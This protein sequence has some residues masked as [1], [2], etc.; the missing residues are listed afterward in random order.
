MNALVRAA[1]L[2]NYQ[3]VAL[4]SGLNPTR[5]LLDE[6]LSPKVLQEPDWMIPVGKV[7]R[8]LHQSAVLSGNEGIG[9]S[10]ARSRKLSNLGPVGLLIRDQVTLRDALNLLVRHLTLLNSALTVSLEENSHSVCIRE[11]LLSAEPGEPTRQRVELALGVMVQVIRQLISKDWCPLRVCFEHAAPRNLDV[12]TR[13]FGT[14]VYFNQ[15]FNGIVCTP[16]DLNARNEFADPAMVRYVHP[17]ME[18]AGS[19]GEDCT[20]EEVRRMILLLLPSGCCS[21]E[22]VS[23]RLGVVPRTIQRRLTEKGETFSSTMNEIRRQL[24]TR[25]VLESKRSLTDISDLLGFTAVS[26]FSRWYQGQFG[27]SAKASRGK[28]VSAIA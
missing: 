18:S 17:I 3:E 12:H 5:M 6:G 19:A 23:E 26:S 13:F 22:R 9:I 15:E 28:F 25:Y 7:G 24:A 2:T 16:A 10:M 8:L 1:C 14:N 21:V 11:L 20:L 4:A 27:C